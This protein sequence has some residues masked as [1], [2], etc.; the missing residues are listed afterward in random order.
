[1]RGDK[2]VKSKLV[3]RP[4]TN[5]KKTKINAI[6]PTEEKSKI[7]K[8]EWLKR[9]LKKELHRI[10]IKIQKAVFKKQLSTPIYSLKINSNCITSEEKA[11]KYRLISEI[12][13]VLH[14]YGHRITK[15]VKNYSVERFKIV[16]IANWDKSS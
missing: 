8:A 2:P 14:N 15:E 9:N 5:L 3:D 7:R 12:L 4:A 11:K 10:R 6:M 16:F 1:M 13:S